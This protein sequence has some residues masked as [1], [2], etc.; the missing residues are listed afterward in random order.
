MHLTRGYNEKE[1]YEQA[2]ED[3]VYE[4]L[5]VAKTYREDCQY[6]YDANGYI[7]ASME[8]KIIEERAV[9]TQADLIFKSTYAMDV[10]ARWGYDPFRISKEVA[11]LYH[12]HAGLPIKKG[13]VLKKLFD[14]QVLA[15]RS[16]GLLQYFV[17][18]WWL[19]EVI[20]EPLEPIDLR[21][22]VLGFSMFV[23]G[24]IL[25]VLAFIYEHYYHAKAKKK[26]AMKAAIEDENSE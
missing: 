6:A 13:S 3:F 1:H 9:I 25:G 16:A 10:R 23:A 8:K 11:R 15:M 21:H 26:I 24:L 18:S 4:K 7:P 20:D 2:P 22:F 14:P 17:K 12:R 19:S 5:V